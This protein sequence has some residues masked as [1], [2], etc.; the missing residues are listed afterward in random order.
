LVELTTYR[1][2]QTLKKIKIVV[3]LVVIASLIV[4]YLKVI[5]PAMEYKSALNMSK[6]GDYQAARIILERLGDYRDAPSQLNLVLALQQRDID[7]QNFYNRCVE[8]YNNREYTHFLTN[9]YDDKEQGVDL[10]AGYNFDKELDHIFNIAVT[11]CEA[12]NYDSGLRLLRDIFFISGDKKI[13]DYAKVLD[14]KFWVTY[15]Q[16]GNYGE[17]A[18][19]YRTLINTFPSLYNYSSKEID[20]NPLYRMYDIGLELYKGE[21]VEEAEKIFFAL[22]DYYNAKAMVN[23]IQ[24]S[25][26]AQNTIPS[27]NIINQNTIPSINISDQIPNQSQVNIPKN[28]TNYDNTINLMNIAHVVYVSSTLKSEGSLNYDKSKLTDR[29]Y[30]T[31]WVEGVSGNG[32]G[33]SIEISFSRDVTISVIVISNGYQK[34]IDILEKNASVKTLILEFDGGKSVLLTFHNPVERRKQKGHLAETFHFKENIT[35]K[36]IKLTIHE[37]YPGT[38]Y[39][40][41]CI[42]EIMFY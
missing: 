8:L 38:K 3:F 24:N 36:N 17:A 29:D 21:N 1:Y 18:K 27:T 23:T 35:T 9:L 5:H 30:A 39:A 40:D 4:L 20:K 26:S 37:T 2:N 25:K 41:T 19:Y 32:E 11:S 13:E 42:S 34:N 15:F 12:G 22:D 6:K 28:D 16:Q 7:A 31:A 10:L 33:E 14:I